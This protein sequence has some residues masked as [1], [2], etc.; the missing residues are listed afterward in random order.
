MGEAATKECKMATFARRIPV[1]VVGI[2]G[3][4]LSLHAAEVR[5]PK[6]VVA[7]IYH[8]AAGP[9]GDYE[10][11]DEKDDLACS[12]DGPRIK[13]LMTRSLREA[14]TAM[15]KF[16]E[17]SNDVIL[18]FDP[19]TDSQDPS[20]HKLVIAAEPVIGDSDIVDVSFEWRYG[21]NSSKRE[22]RYDLKREGGVWLVDNIRGVTKDGVW[23]LRDAI[24][25]PN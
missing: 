23:N 9:K 15:L 3:L 22:I 21:E 8:I 6:E 25:L 19:I 13:A 24:K 2:V 11:C 7:E 4:P 18:D 16:E 1:L 14:M 17:Q 20:V 10:S 5:T 12:I